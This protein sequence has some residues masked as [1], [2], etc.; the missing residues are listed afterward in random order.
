MRLVF[1][2]L[3]QQFKKNKGTQ[4]STGHDRLRNFRQ[5]IGGGRAA[6][7]ISCALGVTNTDVV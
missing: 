1:F 6:V 7:S 2:E 3:S 4:L 5:E